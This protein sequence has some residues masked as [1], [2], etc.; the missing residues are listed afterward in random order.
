MD[1]VDATS[2]VQ[3][4]TTTSYTSDYFDEEHRI[5]FQQVHKHSRF[6]YVDY[7]TFSV[8]QELDGV[9][10]RRFAQMHDEHVVAAH[11]QAGCTVVLARGLKERTYIHPTCI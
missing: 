3:F 9:I 6:H 5:H 2:T 10:V 11:W 4:A 8:T 7:V 1:N